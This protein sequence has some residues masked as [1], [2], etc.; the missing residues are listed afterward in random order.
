MFGGLAFLVRGS[1]AVSAS[2]RGGLMVRV[3]P[4]GSGSLLKTT[5]VRLAEM[6]GRKIPGWFRVD[7]EDVADQEELARWVD[8]GTSY[9]RS[10]PPKG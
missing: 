6:R 5:K 9:A 3:D 10:L 4:A 8:I 1:M 2:G 7:A